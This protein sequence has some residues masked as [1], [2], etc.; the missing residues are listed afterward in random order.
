MYYF[1]ASR[2]SAKEKKTRGAL[3]GRLSDGRRP[4]QPYRWSTGAGELLEIPVTV[5]PGFRVPIHVSYL[6]Y[7]AGVST[8]L[9]RSYFRAALLLCRQTGTA[10]S[11]LLHPLDFMD[12]KDAPALRFFPAMAMPS[13]KKMALLS[14]ALED[15]A[16]DWDI[17]SM[18]EHARSIPVTGPPRPASAA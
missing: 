9:A 18:A 1:S 4:N 2:L 7:L 16:V 3:F 11:L 6:L 10:P 14:G 8:L 13:E 17:R 12:L 15:M 5:M